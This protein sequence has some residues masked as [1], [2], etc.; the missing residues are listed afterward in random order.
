M[1][2]SARLKRNPAK[3][4]GDTSTNPNSACY[5][6]LAP[7][8]AE[9]YGRIDAQETVRQW[10]ELLSTSNF[11]SATPEI[12]RLVDIGC[13]PGAHLVAWRELGL[14]VTG[15]DASPTLLE[16]A[17]RRLATAGTPCPLYLADIRN[18]NALPDL[19]PFDLAVSHFNFPNL[20]PPDEREALFRSLARLVRPGG[21][22]IAD[23]AEPL[24]PPE[25]VNDEIASVIGNLQ[26]DGRF[27]ARLGCYQQQW[28]GPG[29]KCLERFWFG[30]REAGPL[31]AQR[32]GWRLRARMAWQPYRSQA[33]WRT[34]NKE[35]EI[36][37]DVYQRTGDR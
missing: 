24:T 16:Y 6:L 1:N 9:I 18:E 34:P 23:F 5:E 10:W 14:A 15:L 13:G 35:D 3:E 19:P 25:P 29:F 11:I 8:Y 30:F 2:T 17:S 31:L 21:L 4:S 36:L 33:P 26:R 32:T 28:Q 20:F 27:N 12:L 22:W 7:F 37:V